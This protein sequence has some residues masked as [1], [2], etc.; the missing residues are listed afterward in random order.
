LTWRFRTCFK[1]LALLLALGAAAPTFPQAPATASADVTELKAQFE[2]LLEER[3]AARRQEI[4]ALRRTIADLTAKVEALQKFPP[5]PLPPP[6]PAPVPSPPA[7]TAPGPAPTSSTSEP[8][9]IRA[10]IPPAASTAGLPLPHKEQPPEGTPISADIPIKIYGSLRFLSAVDSG[11]LSELQDNLSR[12]G[13]MGRMPWGNTR[14]SVFARAEVGIR[15]IK[16]DTRVIFGGD[17]GSSVGQA[18]SV[19]SSRLGIIG[20]ETPFGTATWGKQ[21]STFYDVGGW[22]DQ[23]MAWGTEAQGSFPTGTDGGISGTGRADQCFRYQTPPHPLKFALQVQNREISPNA[24]NG[25]DTF[26]ASLIWDFP[27][28]FSLGAAYNEVRDGVPNPDVT[29]PKEGDRA[30]IVGLK[31]SQGKWYAAAIYSRFFNH[32]QDDMGTWYSGSGAELFVDCQVAP[33][34]HVYGGFNAKEPDSSYSGSYRMRYLDFG[35]RYIFFRTSFIF[36]E[37]KPE[38]SRNADGSRGRKSAIGTGLFFNF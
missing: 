33:R 32:D 1:P 20:M 19:F 10:E 37:L 17:P 8:P 12:V 28:G 15:L 31:Y 27:K 21:Y 23:F 34:W 36:V 2:R 3:D 25:A 7:G 18:N 9:F 29:Q 11:G 26:G 22:T 24:R 35:F 5:V 13:L 16:N 38:E 4:E 6:S 14:A 30:S